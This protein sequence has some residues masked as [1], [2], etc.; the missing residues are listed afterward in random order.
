MSFL[1]PLY[2][3]AGLGIALPVLFH[4]IRRQ[5]K[6]QIRF[7]SLMFLSPSPPR[8]VRRSKI[9]DLLLLILRGTVL[10]LLAWAFARPFW[11]NSDETGNSMPARSPICAD[12]MAHC[13]AKA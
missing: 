2:L 8:L 7:S 11:R 6:G 12:P 9:D 10:A 3:L 1:T 4:M 5:P 13:R